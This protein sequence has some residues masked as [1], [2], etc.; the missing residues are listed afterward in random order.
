MRQHLARQF[1]SDL[2]VVFQKNLSRCLFWIRFL[3][4]DLA[5]HCQEDPTCTAAIRT[6]LNVQPDCVGSSPGQP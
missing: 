3:H 2:K 4:A 5:L 1:S 6:P